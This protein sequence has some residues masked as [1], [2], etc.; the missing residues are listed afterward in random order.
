L[1]VKI[2]FEDLGA[3]FIPVNV[4]VTVD[5]AAP[6]VGLKPINVGFDG[7]ACAAA[8]PESAHVTAA[9]R[10]SHRMVATRAVCV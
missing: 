7:L 4:I 3:K 6:C 2:R 5:P 9:T 1:G 10:S 8:N